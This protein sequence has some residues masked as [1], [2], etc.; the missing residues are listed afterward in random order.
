M[1]IAHLSAEAAP[2]AKT[3][4]LGDVVGALPIAQARLGHQVTVWIPF[5]R[6][7]R[8]E[9]SR[10]SVTPDQALGPFRIDLGFEP[11]EAE[12]LLTRLPGSSVP[13][14][15]VRSDRFFD[16]PFYYDLDIHKEDDGIKRFSVFVR[17]ALSALCRLDLVPDVLHAHD[18]H[19]A[20][21]PMALA[22][23][24][25]RDPLFAKTASMLTIHNIAYQGV[26]EPR[27]FPY[28]GLPA[29][30]LPATL[31]RGG[32]NLLK[33]GLLAADMVTAVSPSYGRE[34]ATPEG[35]AGLD[36][37]VVHRQPSIVGILNGIDTGVWDPARDTKIPYNYSIN[38]FSNKLGNR[39]ALLAAAGM[40]P[41]DPGL[42]VGLVG[43]LAEQKGYD[44]FFPV[45]PE[46]AAQG[47]RFVFLGS[48]EQHLEWQA[49]HWQAALPGRFWA[50]IGFDDTLA[51]LIEAGSDAFLMP[52]RFEPCGLGQLYALAYG[53]PP[54]VRRVGGL[55][56]TV[57]PYDGRN[58]DRAT[59]FGFEQVDPL[60]LRDAV[61]W[62]SHCFRDPALWRRLMRNGMALDYSWNR[63]A[64]RYLEIYRAMISA[65][66]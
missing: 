22:W 10:R 48:G 5:Y 65:R 58:A 53:T 38:D 3:G 44:L 9:L 36:P 15:M 46:L 14:Y 18:W 34:I 11:H 57:V 17:A 39:K 26:Y 6:Q 1:K 16:R 50:R 35:G 49:R 60:A 63:S 27:D 28:L 21:A 2:L 4:G 47:I 59:G 13:L 52:S 30:R 32:V 19:A 61:S 62:A 45:L 12:I 31:W 7:V 25:P 37:V 56:D 64:E 40:D 29:D 43:R 23:D 42:V 41:G 51:H 8:E 20:P 54:I 24:R 33:G 66:E 55:I